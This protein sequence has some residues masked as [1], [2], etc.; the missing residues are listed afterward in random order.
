M[1]EVPAP[2]G[3]MPAPAPH[4]SPAAEVDL[5]HLP[6]LLGEM[7]RLR[8]ILWTRLALR[9]NRPPPTEDRLLVTADAASPLGVSK[10]W[11]YRN[12]GRLPFT[13]RVSEGLLRF[14]AKGIDRWIASRAA[15]P[16]A[17]CDCTVGGRRVGALNPGLPRVH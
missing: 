8:A 4:T 6:G 3:A 11:V 9:I 15:S 10:D 13:V 17:G 5:D 1:A 12:S 2:V 7:E 14:S 16:D